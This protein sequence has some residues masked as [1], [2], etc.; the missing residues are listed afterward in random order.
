MM[1]LTNKFYFYFYLFQTQ[2]EPLID[3]TPISAGIS[4][5]INKTNTIDTRT[6]IPTKLQATKEKTK[7]NKR[8]S[9]F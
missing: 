7:L 8:A 1:R 5:L 9:F 3:A 4:F 6:S 2:T